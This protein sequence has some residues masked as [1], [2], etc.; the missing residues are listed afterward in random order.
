MDFSAALQDPDPARSL[1]YF[2]RAYNFERNLLGQCKDKK[3]RHV[4]VPLADGTAKAHGNF[5]PLQ[6]V[7]YLILEMAQG[8]IRNEVAKIFS[9]NGLTF[10]GL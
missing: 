9:P 6:N 8:D 2:T 10:I 5:G 1:E 3:L 4:V 7:P